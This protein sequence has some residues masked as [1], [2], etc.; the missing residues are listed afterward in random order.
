MLVIRFTGGFN[1]KRKFDSVENRMKYSNSLKFIR[2]LA[3]VLAGLEGVRRK[4]GR[5]CNVL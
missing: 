3:G 2:Y 4:E 5:G 1:L